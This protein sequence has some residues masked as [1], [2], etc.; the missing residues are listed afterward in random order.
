MFTLFNDLGYSRLQGA[1]FNVTKEIIDSIGTIY[2]G[3]TSITM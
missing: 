1:A 2:D 3:Y